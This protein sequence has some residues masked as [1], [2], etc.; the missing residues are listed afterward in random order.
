MRDLAALSVGWELVYVAG[1]GG[2]RLSCLPA[3]DLRRIRLYLGFKSRSAQHP[4]GPRSRVFRFFCF[5]L[6]CESLSFACPKESNQRKKT[7]D[8]RAGAKRAG[9]LR[10][11]IRRDAA[12]TRVALAILKHAGRTGAC[13][14]HP[15]ALRFS[16]LQTGPEYRRPIRN[17]FDETAMA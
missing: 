2:R 7:P 17:C 16:S 9:A 11:S 12:R 3:R 13:A 5:A 15:P 14:G 1:F 10:C 4:A 6:L 8:L